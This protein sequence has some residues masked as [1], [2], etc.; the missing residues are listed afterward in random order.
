MKKSETPK[1]LLEL[2]LKHRSDHESVESNEMVNARL[3]SFMSDIISDAKPSDVVVCF[4]H[5]F[6]LRMLSKVISKN[7]KLKDWNYNATSVKR[8]NGAVDEFEVNKDGENIEIELVRMGERSHFIT[9][10]LDPNK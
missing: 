3:T 7:Y 6:A 10:S 4:T 2:N 1:L 9:Q 5:G 8:F